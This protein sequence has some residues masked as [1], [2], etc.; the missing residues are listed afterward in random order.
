V[1]IVHTIELSLECDIEALREEFSQETEGLS[2]WA[3]II[4]AYENGVREPFIQV[5]EL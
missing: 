2:D 3:A 1:R 4:D 5:T